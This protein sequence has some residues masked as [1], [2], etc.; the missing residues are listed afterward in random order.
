MRPH[1]YSL[2][3][4]R[5]YFPYLLDISEVQFHRKKKAQRIEEVMSAK[6]REPKQNKDSK[7]L[8]QS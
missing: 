8:N 2:Y 3:E 1:T 4:F 6:C 7:T 5:R